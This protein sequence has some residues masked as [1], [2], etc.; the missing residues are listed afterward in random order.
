MKKKVLIPSEAEGLVT[1]ICVD[2]EKE[3]LIF[4]AEVEGRLQD[5]FELTVADENLRLF[6]FYSTR[7]FLKDNERKKKWGDNKVLKVLLESIK[8]PVLD[9]V[10]DS[11]N[12]KKINLLMKEFMKDIVSK[13]PDIDLN[14]SDI[15]FAITEID[16]KI[17]SL[18][19]K[20]YELT[21]DEIEI[22]LNSM[23]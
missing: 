15:E 3:N 20:L 5:V 14:L 13:Y 18:V 11:E 19:F 22:V 17:N 4:K 8:I 6:L 1:K 12:I 10:S 21:M 23:S 7:K 9:N 2:L 16:T